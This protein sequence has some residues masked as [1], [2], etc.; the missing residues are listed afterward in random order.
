MQ[1]KLIIMKSILKCIILL[2]MLLHIFSREPHERNFFRLSQNENKCEEA[3]L[4]IGGTPCAYDYDV[5]EDPAEVENNSK[6]DIMVVCCNKDCEPRIVDD[7]YHF[8]P[9]CTGKF[10]KFTC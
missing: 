6:Y 8:L 3:C 9:Y 2:L 10:L 5:P 4:K 1:I 7:P